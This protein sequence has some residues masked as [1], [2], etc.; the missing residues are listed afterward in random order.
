[1]LPGSENELIFRKSVMSVKYHRQAVSSSQAVQA[2]SSRSEYYLMPLSLYLSRFNAI[3]LFYCL[4]LCLSVSLQ[5][6]L[7]VSLYLCISVSL[8]LCFYVFLCIFVSLFPLFFISYL[9]ISYTHFN[10]SLFPFLMLLFFPFLSSL[11]YPISLLISFC[12]ISIKYHN[13]I[14]IH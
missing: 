2:V 3:L 9:F 10:A 12:L 13:I 7:S 5:L 11:F 1:M 14:T 8:Y 4:F 6:C